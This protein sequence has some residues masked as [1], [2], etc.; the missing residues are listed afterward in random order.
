MKGL[1][2]LQ[3]DIFLVP[4]PV[5]IFT[6]CIYEYQVDNNWLLACV[7]VS[8]S[9][10]KWSRSNICIWICVHHVFHVTAAV[11][12]IDELTI[13]LLHWL[14]EFSRLAISHTH[15][16]KELTLKTFRSLSVSWHFWTS[17]VCEIN[18]PDVNPVD[19]ET[20]ITEYGMGLPL[21]KKLLLWLLVAI[22]VILS[23]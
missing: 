8:C 3:G 1:K 13:D 2:L 5:R 6:T 11:P 22:M 12:F 18:S 4:F 14:E 10:R 21:K 15:W 16:K 19:E 9:C 17:A 7:P 23:T 20:P